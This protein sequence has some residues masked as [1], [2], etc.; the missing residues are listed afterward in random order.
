MISTVTAAAATPAI[1]AVSGRLSNNEN[2]VAHRNNSKA[3]KTDT[4]PGA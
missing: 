4:A 2:S 1:A 3:K